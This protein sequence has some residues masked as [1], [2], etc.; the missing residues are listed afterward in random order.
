M[1]RM[2][3]GL[4]VVTLPSREAMGLAAAR[5]AAGYLRAAVAE[6]GQAVMLLAAAP[7]QAEFL[8]ELARQPGVPWEAVR[9]LQLDEYVGL[10]PG[11]AGSF[12]SWLRRHLVQRVEGLRFV[13]MDGTASPQEECA[14]YAALLEPAPDLACVG[15]GENGHL[16]FNDPPDARLDDP[17]RVRVV[18]LSEASRWQ[19]VHD[20][21]FP[22]IEAVPTHALTLTVPAI[23]SSRHVV[24]VV[25]GARKAA[26]VRRALLEPVDAGCP[27]SAL[28]RHGDAQLFLDPAA[29]AGLAAVPSAPGA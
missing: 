20:G 25:P 10:G 4:R 19:Q 1:L 21:C 29:A 11:A 17:R 5:V 2:A 15:F 28:R 23:L 16:A 22:S 18:A 8:D 3:D 9:A 6:R 24:A 13:A 7:S 12:S 14:R 26:A 27:A